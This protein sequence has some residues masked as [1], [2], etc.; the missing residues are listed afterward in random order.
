MINYYILVLTKRII[1][2]TSSAIKRLENDQ[3]GN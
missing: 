2:K 1:N 3:R